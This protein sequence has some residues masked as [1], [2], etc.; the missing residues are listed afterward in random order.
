MCLLAQI[1]GMA[2]QSL[3]ALI[4]IV[5]ESVQLLVRVI[6]KS[7]GVTVRAIGVPSR[8]SRRDRRRG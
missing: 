6:H 7:I 8:K 5:G 3:G 1:A 4:E 2:P